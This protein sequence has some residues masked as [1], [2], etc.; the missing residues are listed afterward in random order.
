MAK[1]T[2]KPSVKPTDAA[3][4]EKTAAAQEAPIDDA[5]QEK[6]AAT[7]EAPKEGIRVKAENGL[8]L[9]VGPHK[10]YDVAARLADGEPVKELELPA[11]LGVPGWTP[12]EAAAG[13][14]W[15]MA[16]FLRPAEE[17]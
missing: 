10:S 4:Q 12:V 1:T 13:R 17:S 2:R 16:E 14:G 7:Q 15:V 11:G 9:R 5:A 3:A 8:F 6:A